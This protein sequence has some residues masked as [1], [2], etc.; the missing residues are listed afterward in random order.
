[1]FIDDDNDIDSDSED[2]TKIHHTEK[3]IKYFS[4]VIKGER[5]ISISLIDNTRFYINIKTNTLTLS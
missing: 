3:N 5:F 1:M 4:N 2:D